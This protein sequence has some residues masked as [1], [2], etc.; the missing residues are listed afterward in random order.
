MSFYRRSDD[1]NSTLLMT[2][3]EYVPKEDN[4]FW[5]DFVEADV[6]PNIQDRN[7]WIKQ[8]NSYGQSC[9]HCAAYSNNYNFIPT[10]YDDNGEKVKMSNEMNSFAYK[11]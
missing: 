5:M 2:L 3:A 9:I 8:K 4:R 10:M 11:L 1:Y 6:T 7:K